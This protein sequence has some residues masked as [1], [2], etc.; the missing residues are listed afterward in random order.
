MIP[1]AHG[2]H[3]KKKHG[4][5]FLRQ[6]SIVDHML[7][8]V[9]LTSTSSVFEIGCGDGFLTKAI[10][11]TPIERLWVFEIDPQWATYVQKQYP[12]PRMHMFQQNI[13]EVDFSSFEQ[14]KPWVLL[15]NLPY[16][17]TF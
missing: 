7:E 1:T 14:H 2:I 15:A 11:A 17:I 8:A 10:L 16:Q 6:Q 13:L 4:Q 3:L 9:S 5:H 12:D